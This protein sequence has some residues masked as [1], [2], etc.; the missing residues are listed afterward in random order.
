MIKDSGTR[1]DFGGAVRDCADGKGRFD[2]M[3][4]QEIGEII[5][6]EFFILM[7]E[8]NYD[9]AVNLVIDCFWE[10][11][12][13][14]LLD[15]A[16]LFEN[17]LKKYGKDN[18]KAGSG[19]PEESYVDSACRHYCKHIAGWRDEEHAAACV[20]NLVCL[21]YSIKNIYKTEKCGK[22]DKCIYFSH[23]P[24]SEWFMKCCLD[25][26]AFKEGKTN[27]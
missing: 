9:D 7:A 17:G 12:H 1:R 24:E 22:C 25:K 10:S 15:L 2:I 14:A 23:N 6:D 21:I 13:E 11:R 18:W 5:E 16:K 26:C 3:P 4:L 20:W 19:I 8:K 27:E